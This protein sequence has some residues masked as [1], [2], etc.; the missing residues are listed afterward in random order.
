MISIAAWQDHLFHVLYAP[1]G[2]LPMRLLLLLLVLAY[3]LETQAA[4]PEPAGAPPA[5]ADEERAAQAR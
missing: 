2:Q 4:Q 3:M 5:Q 1:P